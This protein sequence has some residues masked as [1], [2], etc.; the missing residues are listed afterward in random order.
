MRINQNTINDVFKSEPKSESELTKRGY[1]KIDTLFCDKTGW[2]TDGIALTPNE[3]LER[4]QELVNMYGV[5]HT[6][7]IDEGAFQL[8]LGAFIKTA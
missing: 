6:Y 4:T 7:I 8:Y 5:I 2:D 3:V 1:K